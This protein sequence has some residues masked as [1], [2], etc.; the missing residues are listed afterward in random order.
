MEE[1]REICEP[2]QGVCSHFNC[3]SLNICIV[4]SYT[5]YHFISQE[6]SNVSSVHVTDEKAEAWRNELT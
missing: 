4:Q 6:A 2:L 5:H 3:Q 1:P